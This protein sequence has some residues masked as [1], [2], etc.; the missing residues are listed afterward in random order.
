MLLFFSKEVSKM[1]KLPEKYHIIIEFDSGKG[2]IK[3]KD[4]EHLMKLKD[5]VYGSLA[6]ENYFNS[7]DPKFFYD[8]LKEFLL[9]LESSQVPYFGHLGTGV[10]HPFFKDEEEN[11]RKGCFELMKRMRCKL[12]EYGFGISR[13]DFLEAFDIK[14]IQRVKLRHDP[15]GKLN[16]GKVI[17]FN[18]EKSKESSIK[19][20]KAIQPTE[21]IVSKKI[22]APKIIESIKKPSEKM[23]N[24]IKEA[25]ITDKVE[26]VV[27]EIKKVVE[28][29][30]VPEGKTVGEVLKEIDI[31]EDKPTFENNNVKMT[32]FVQ[33]VEQEEE[34]YE[35]GELRE[36][37][38]KELEKTKEYIDLGG[39]QRQH[40]ESI[41][42]FK[43]K[44]E[45]VDITK[46]M[47]NQVSNKKI[48][49]KPD[50]FNFKEA[51]KR[52]E[53]DSSEEIDGAAIP[54]GKI[55]DSEKDLINSVLGNRFGFGGDKK[56]NK[57]SEKSE[58][59]EH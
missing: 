26:E 15:F 52:P 39:K 23:V 46:I 50:K 45:E 43:K 42:D 59:E 10:I 1:L 5:N 12:G 13:K 21:E 8:K 24:L 2:K 25:E 58:E 35:E 44:I 57:D 27:Q 37:K 17:K 18:K 4:Y 54:R 29:K 11:K 41:E 40:P 20:S 51:V 55:S 16:Q 14:I 31:N 36:K 9:F 34:V 28:E 7:E 48:E 56:E 47:T 6:K 22:E 32:D 38:L 3:G 33:R 30:P 49:E 19:K 53:I